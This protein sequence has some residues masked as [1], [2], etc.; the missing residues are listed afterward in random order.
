MTKSIERTDLFE[1]IFALLQVQMFPNIWVLAS[2][3]DNLPPIEIIKQPRVD[4]PRELAN[5]ER[6]SEV[7][8]NSEAYPT[9]LIEELVQQFDI[10]EHRRI[11][12]QLVRDDIQERFRTK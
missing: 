10:D 8:L 1:L 12:S 4:L 2:E 9:H 5:V 3:S 11:V 7:L 6:L